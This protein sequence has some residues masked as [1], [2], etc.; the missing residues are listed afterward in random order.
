M[1][2]KW[3]A[4]TPL[5]QLI[6]STE[7]CG[8][9]VSVT[10]SSLWRK[11]SRHTEGIDLTR[12]SRTCGRESCQISRHK[13]LE[14][15]DSANLCLLLPVQAIAGGISPVAGS[16]ALKFRI[17]PGREKLQGSGF[18]TSQLSM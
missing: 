8:Q 18:C 16:F 14:F 17:L 2:V 3:G 5:E 11:E 10:V 7:L 13:R 12:L 9:V 6:A 15:R 1:Q 4:H